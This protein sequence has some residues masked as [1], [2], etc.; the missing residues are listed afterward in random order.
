MPDPKPPEVPVDPK[1]DVNVAAGLGK[2]IIGPLTQMGLGG[3]A[4]AAFIWVFLAN[5][6]EGR[7]VAERNDARLGMMVDMAAKQASVEREL[8]QSQSQKQWE[9]IGQNQKTLVDVGHTLADLHKGLDKHEGTN[10]EQLKQLSLIAD[11]LKNPPKTK[12]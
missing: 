10:L 12:N 6:E 7:K 2:G 9:A 4:L 8:F 5:A 1:P 11:L 3:C